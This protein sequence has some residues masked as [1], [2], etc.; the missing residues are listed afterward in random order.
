MISDQNIY[1]CSNSFCCRENKLRKRD[2]NEE[3]E[4]DKEETKDDLTETKP[5]RNELTPII[6]GTESIKD[7]HFDEKPI[8]DGAKIP[9]TNKPV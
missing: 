5:R 1:R 6:N 7:E 8:L 4:D 9:G 2:E 3:L